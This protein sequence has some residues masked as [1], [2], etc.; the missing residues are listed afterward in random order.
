[1]PPILAVKAGRSL[2]RAGLYWNAACLEKIRAPRFWPK[3]KLEPII[4]A[5]RRSL[6]KQAPLVLPECD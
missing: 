4:N 3:N 1:M 6:P 5:W 2:M